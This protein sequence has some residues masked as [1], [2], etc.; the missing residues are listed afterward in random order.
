[1]PPVSPSGKLVAI[2][3]LAA[4]IAGGVTA[5]GVTI[6]MR[7]DLPLPLVAQSGA[8]PAPTANSSSSDESAI[9]QAVRHASPAVVA[10]TISKQVPV[11]ERYY[12]R[13]PSPF[14][15]D[16]FSFSVPQLRER[17]T[18]EQD[19]GGGSGF[20]V[21]ADGYIVT[22]RHVVADDSAS[23]TV[24][25]NDGEHHNAKV[26]ARDPVLDLAVLKIDGIH[27]FLSFA[28]SDTLAVG[29]TAIA[30]GNAL[31][32]YRNTVSV[33]VVSGLARTIVASDGAGSSETLDQLIQTDAAINQGNSGGPL[34]NARGEV[35]GVNVAVASNAENIGFAIAANSARQVVDSVREHGKIVRPYL[36]IRYLP[37]T[38]SVKEKNGL[39]V[40]YGVLVA[41]GETREELAVIPGSPADK[42]GIFENDII[43]AIDGVKLDDGTS[44]GSHIRS[45]V[46]GSTITLTVIREGAELSVPVVLEAMNDH[47]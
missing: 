34:L 2:A 26:V 15:G 41:R 23:Y 17:G 37:I 46:V 28:D 38:E 8:E 27:D 33:G 19:V 43:T 3:V 9:V 5:L 21:S 13:V 20:L 47:S 6:A 14:F 11:Y 30:I 7:S 36:G 18:R 31:A 29:Q 32:E 42:A 1:M 10:I 12:E 25:T 16:G 22:N 39:P 24:Y 4:S 44:F 35:I 40:A 45:K